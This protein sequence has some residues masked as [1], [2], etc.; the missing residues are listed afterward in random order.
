MEELVDVRRGIYWGCKSKKK[1]FP[2]LNDD[3]CPF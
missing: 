1:E 2:D 3:Q